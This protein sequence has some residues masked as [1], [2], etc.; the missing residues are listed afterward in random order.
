MS[1]EVIVAFA[2]LT[3]AQR[4]GGVAVIR[5]GGVMGPIHAATHDPSARAQ[6]GHLPT[7]RAGRN[8]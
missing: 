2:F 8:R 7:L 1:T 3:G 5:D 6:R 4:R